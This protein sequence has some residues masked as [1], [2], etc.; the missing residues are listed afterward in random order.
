MVVDAETLDCAELQAMW[1]QRQKSR[2]TAKLSRDFFRACQISPA[3]PPLHCS[4]HPS[5]RRPKQRRSAIMAW[6]QD[7]R[8]DERLSLYANEMR[9]KSGLSMKNDVGKR[10]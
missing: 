7:D 2:S 10:S 6:S 1:R 9:P 8:E 4:S 3:K 5:Q